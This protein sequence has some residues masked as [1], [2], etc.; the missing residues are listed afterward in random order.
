MK[1][2]TDTKYILLDYLL[3]LSKKEFSF[4]FV[5]PFLLT[6]L[7]YLISY[8]CNILIPLADILPRF[9]GFFGAS[10]GFTLLL[11]IIIVSLKDTK[12]LNK[13]SNRKIAGV[14]IKNF[15]FVISNLVYSA[16]FSYILLFLASIIFFLFS[17]TL[18]KYNLYIIL[19]LIFFSLHILFL[20]LRN[21]TTFYLVIR[22]E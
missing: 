10:M 15:R 4:D 2:Y 7:F 13:I 9:I 21:M 17:D 18:I 1:I 3:L 14:E 8:S 19:L 12:I 5:F 6:T 16:C 11:I 22:D 20:M